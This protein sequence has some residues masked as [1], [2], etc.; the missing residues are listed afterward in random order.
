MSADYS[1]E[2][3]N[4]EIRVPA[5]FKPNNLSVATVPYK[6]MQL[7]T[8]KTHCHSTGPAE[9]EGPFVLPLPD[10]IRSKTFSVITP[11]PDF[12]TFR[13]IREIYFDPH[14]YNRVVYSNAH[15]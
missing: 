2:V 12:E 9:R 3:K 6:S 5:F 13:R 11:P 4:I 7:L 15:L 8:T 10:F 14:L 1:F